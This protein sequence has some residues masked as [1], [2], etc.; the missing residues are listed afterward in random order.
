MSG[1][2]SIK[3]Y[4]VGGFHVWIANGFG[5][6]GAGTTWTWNGAWKAAY[7]RLGVYAFKDGAGVDVDDE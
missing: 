7:R 5:R 3:V 6:R 1:D 2:N 4:R